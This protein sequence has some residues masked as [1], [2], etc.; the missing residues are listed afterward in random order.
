M[1]SL[2]SKFRSNLVAV[3]SLTLVFI[4]ACG[5]LAEIPVDG[6]WPQFRGP[7]RDLIS[8]DTGLLEQWPAEGPRLVWKADGLGGGYSA[9]SIVRGRIFGMSYRGDDEVVWALDRASGKEIWKTRIAEAN[10]QISSEARAG[11]SCTPTI[12][13]DRLYALGVSGDLV[14]LDVAT[15][16]KHWEKNLVSD[17]G[18]RVP[19]WGYAESPLVDGEKVVATPG[20]SAATL[21]ALD[22]D[23]GEVTWKASV[24]EGD[25]AAYSS[26]IVAGSGSTRQYIQYL[27]E[28][29]VGIRA[30]D[31]EYL[32]RENSSVNEA[33]I[34]CSSPVYHDGY[35]FSASAYG[36]GG[37]LVRLVPESNGFTAK[38]EYKTNRMKSHHGGFFL[39]DGYLYGTDEEILTCLEFLTGEVAWQN[40]SVGKG[41]VLYADG[42][43]YLRSEKGPVALVEVTPEGYR[44]K[45]RFDQP[46]RSDKAAWAYPVV[47][48]GRLYLR[49]QD[50]LLC[51]DVRESDSP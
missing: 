47:A 6:D 22:K 9:P 34:H 20:G 38:L 27:A 18:G 14:C 32:W 1:I 7:S 4:S 24:P 21:V 45:G 48:G 36:K 25:G 42:H 31:G 49:D 30:G 8:A 13:G 26:V 50:I 17:F 3:L 28:G 43:L 41:S 10:V 39:L 12:D 40:R 51:Y 33:Q 19:N 29:V 23:N 2:T 5:A 44:E 46:H 35:V 16:K 15:G 37:A 11:S